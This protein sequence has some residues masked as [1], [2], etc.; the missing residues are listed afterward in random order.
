M[1][2]LSLCYDHCKNL[3]ND[4]KTKRPNQLER[5]LC[6]YIRTGKKFHKII[7]YYET[8]NDVHQSTHC[9]IDRNTG[10]VY[11]A[12]SYAQPAKGIRYNILRDMDILRN[13]DWAGGY[14]YKR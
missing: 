4:Y 8:E 11:K 2:I 9:F 6:F 1:N 13:A 7:F 5:N 3:E 12:A 14:L 10:D